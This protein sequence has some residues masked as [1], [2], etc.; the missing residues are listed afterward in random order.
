MTDSDALL[1]KRNRRETRFQYA[2]R[3]AIAVAFV[4][5]AVLI[6]T[7]VKD[8]Y[9]AFWQ[10]YIQLEVHLDEEVIDK[11]GTRDPDTMARANY[12]KLVKDALYTHFPEV[13]KRKE[14]RQLAELASKGAAYDLADM[15]RENNDLIGKT[16]QLKLLASSEVDVW[17]KQGQSDALDE[18]QVEWLTQLDAEGRILS[19][20]N[21]RF[22][23]SG[24]SR[25]PE[26]AGVLGSVVGSL[27]TVFVCLLVSFPFG[28]ATAVYLEEFAPVNR[29]TDWIEIN[30]NN[31]AAV[32]SIIFGLLGL[33]IYLNFFGLPRSS[34]LVGGMTLA[35]MI[36]P[37]IIITTRVSLKSVPDTIRDAAR[38]LGASPLQVV[39]HHSL[40]LAM[41]GIMTGT[42][43][44]I[45]RAIGETAPLLMIGMVAFIVDI[46]AGVTSPSTVMPV[47]VYLWADS[48]E[49]AFVEKT[50][51]AIM[52]LLFF[53][54]AF[55]AT[56]VYLRKKYERRW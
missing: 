17:S 11:K 7:I 36:L 12:A 9:T 37:T 38:G 54:V 5:L 32:P 25:E 30:I 19:R 22:F 20:F 43:L 27:F 14:K 2:G 31:L 47:Q 39:L 6:V 26:L 23:T 51:A 46:P 56:A 18:R 45:A 28:V 40:P 44:G 42:I 1:A 13:D 24:D 21:T 52:V 53:L 4:A 29:F 33:A 49:K 3:V 50:S 41:P 10:T 34:S 55:N 35:L 48:P 8:G 15:I 16:V